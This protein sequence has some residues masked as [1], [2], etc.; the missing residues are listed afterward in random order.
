MSNTMQAGAKRN[1]WQRQFED[2]VTPSQVVFDVT[3]GILLPIICFIFDPIAFTRRGGF[4]NPFFPKIHEYALFTYLLSAVAMLTLALWLIFWRRVRSWSG[5]IGGILL[6]GA[7]AST[8]IGVIILPLSLIGLMFGIGI[9]GFIPFL[10]SFVYLRNATRAIRRGNLYSGK[11]LL[12][13]SVILG[14]VF[15]VAA[16]SAVHWR[17]NSIVSQSIQEILDGDSTAT[18]TAISRI[19]DLRWFADLDR[20]VLAY[21]T[22]TDST[23]KAR[24]AGAYKEITGDE[25]SNRLTILR[26]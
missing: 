18:E 24:L 9:L 12:I 17:I 7:Y 5:S 8:A 20:I 21:E 4:G 22:E 3:L 23:R 25:I 10:T 2:L 19:R 11:A 16:P 1:F 13:G 15:L 26:D 14:S 6:A